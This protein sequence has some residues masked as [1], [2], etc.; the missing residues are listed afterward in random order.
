MIPRA[1]LD[2][3]LPLTEQLDARGMFLRPIQGTPV[4][5]LVRATRADVKFNVQLDGGGWYPDLDNIE[6]IANKAPTDGMPNAHDAAMDSLV[7]IGVNAVRD[8]MSFAKNVV[9][10]AIQELVDGVAQGLA[11][12]NPSALLGLEVKIVEL[13]KLMQ[14][15]AFE[16]AVRKYEDTPLDS[17]S[18]NVNMPDLSVA[19]IAELALAGGAGANSEIKEFLSSM[20]DAWLL[21]LWGE[22]FQIRPGDHA[23]TF[24]EIISGDDG[25]PAAVGIFLL[26]RRLVDQAPAGVQMSASGLAFK[27]AEFRN[28]SAARLAR[29]LNEQQLIEKAGTVVR[30]QAGRQVTVNGSAYRQ[31][32]KDGGSNEQLFGGLVSGKPSYLA[33]DLKSRGGELKAAWD[34]HAAITATVEAGRRVI[35]TKELLAQCFETQVN[36]VAQGDRSLAGSR[37]EIIS[38]FNGMLENVREDELSDIYGLALRLVCRSRFANTEA[39]RILTGIENVKRDNPTLDIREAAAISM[40]QYVAWWVGTQFKVEIL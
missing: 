6:F 8:H 22:V 13:P 2:A 40:I 19:D 3:A 15:G 35:R 20:G 17:P 7:Q 36:S 27:M 1:S 12:V 4:D 21:R 33:K 29:A 10:P 31:F 9:A 14:S 11:Q 26:S 34:K 5:A 37:M 24:Q 23:R 32:L 25:I 16:A 38:L 18:M 30:K 28:Q 39:E